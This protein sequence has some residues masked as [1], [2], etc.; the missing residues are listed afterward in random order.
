[1]KLGKEA[2]FA[3]IETALF[4]VGAGFFVMV[5]ILP[6]SPNWALIMGIIFG[7]AGIALWLFPF[8]AK[9][10]QRYK[11]APDVTNITQEILGAEADDD[12]YELHRSTPYLHD[13]DE[14][15]ATPLHTSTTKPTK[16]TKAGKPTKPATSLEPTTPVKPIESTTENSTTPT[17]TD[18]QTPTN[19]DT[20]AEKTSTAP[21]V[22]RT[23]H[24]TDK[25]T[26]TKT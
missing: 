25:A 11:T 22:K 7:L 15:I 13:D 4:A 6:T 1:M 5:L 24:K 12:S 20:I 18:D 23:P 8:F 17:T 19:T 3:I 14:I 10:I 26:P 16:P 2:L 21:T 9:L